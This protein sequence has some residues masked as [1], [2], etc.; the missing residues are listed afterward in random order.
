MNIK[1]ELY[2]IK[3]N[4]FEGTS[5]DLI[6]I[7]KDDKMDIDEVPINDIIHDYINYLN[8]KKESIDINAVSKT[9]N[10]A[11]LLLK[12]KSQ[13]LLPRNTLEDEQNEENDDEE[14]YF[15]EMENNERYLKEYEKYKKVIHYLKE[16]AEKQR[17]VF[18]PVTEMDTPEDNLEI[19]KVELSDL[20]IALEKVL[21]T[22]KN[23][24]YVPIKKRYFTV[25]EKMKIISDCL[26]KNSQGLSF[27]FFMENAKCKL[28]I[29]IIF[30][31][32]LQLI[33]FKKISCF[34]KKNYDNILFRLKGV[35]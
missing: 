19:E 3:F 14:N 11:A 16:K 21:S 29:I 15:I 4:K 26:R 2:T 27:S 28:E 7:I 33:Y 12:M 10:H 24:E 23:K 13:K 31:A 30:L 8:G 32:L 20:L 35:H 17:N 1:E 22:K 5:I 6:K 9:I 18:F 34:Q 25:A